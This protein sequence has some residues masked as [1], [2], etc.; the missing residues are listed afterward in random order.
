MP[1]HCIVEADLDHNRGNNLELLELIAM[2]DSVVA[3]KVHNQPRNATYSSPNIQNSLLNILGNM[4]RKKIY[5]EV[6]EADAYSMLCVQTKDYSKQE[7]LSLVLRYVDNKA[8]IHEHFLTY[9]E[10][11]DLDAKSLTGYIVNALKTYCLDPKLNVSQGVMM[12]H[13]I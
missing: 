1:R 6:R 11:K 12:V 5:I 2:H 4:I 3:D 7:Q 10:V 9:M 8:V 13:L